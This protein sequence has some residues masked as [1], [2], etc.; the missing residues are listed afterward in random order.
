MRA[1]KDDEAVRN[2][3]R[4]K[5]ILFFFPKVSA[6]LSCLLLLLSVLRNC[7]V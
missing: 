2:K 1:E 7:K 6:F 4:M 5:F 3:V